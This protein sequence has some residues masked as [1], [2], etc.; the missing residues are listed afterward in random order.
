MLN[1]ARFCIFVS[2]FDSLDESEF[3]VMIIRD[4]V[5]TFRKSL[6][7]VYLLNDLS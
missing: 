4:K 7:S 6:K 5:A 2:R 3:A 1:A